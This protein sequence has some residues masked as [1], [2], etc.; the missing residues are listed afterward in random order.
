MDPITHGLLGALTGRAFAGQ[1]KEQRVSLKR[2]TLTCTAGALFPDLD[3]LLF[4][5]DPLEFLAYWH[6]GVSHSLVMLPLWALLL[7]GGL[8]LVSRN[9]KSW[10]IY[11]GYAALGIGSHIGVDLLTA[12][13]VQL[14][15]PLSN[16]R[17]ALSLS[18]V[19]DPYFTLIIMLGLLFSRLRKLSDARLGLLCLIPYLCLQGAMQHQ[20]RVLGIN[21]LAQQQP[22][23]GPHCAYVFPQPFSP[24]HWQ[25]LLKTDR[26]Y[27][28]ARV[29]LYGDVL[30]I[31]GLP[32]PRSLIT[33]ANSFSA[34]QTPRWRER[35]SWGTAA[36]ESLA[37]EAWGQPG[38]A[39][40]RHFAR[41]PI[42]E[43]IDNDATGDC[44][45]F[46]DLRYLLP[47]ITPFFRYGMC[48]TK[49]QHIWKPYRLKRHQ[50]QARQPL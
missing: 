7:G 6:R 3:Y 11:T 18:Y 9:R 21:Q 44:V 45:W 23:A 24:F 39:P 34:A 37:R 40:F 31:P 20:A 2:L 12:Y 50:Q 27:L 4:W 13:G 14:F 15:A 47:G 38:L 33:L 43:R 32:W 26:G 29:Q 17:P 22:A 16:F 36:Q 30:I 19:V 41:F 42:L 1:D 35:P 5:V 28:E 48:R 10:R 49:G 8:A 25:L 46:T